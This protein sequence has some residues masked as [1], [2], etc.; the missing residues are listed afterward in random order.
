MHR[1]RRPSNASSISST[2]SNNPITKTM[3]SARNRLAS[4]GQSKVSSTNSSRASTPPSDFADASGRKSSIGSERSCSQ[5]PAKDVS[6]LWRCMLELQNEYGCYHSTRMDLA[7]DAGDAALDYMPSRFIID[8]LNDSI[9][10]LPE[11][12]WEKLDQYLR[13]PDTAKEMK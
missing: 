10:D 5:I 7:V 2:H 8:T 13:Q 9:F 6:E 3:R 12:A 1:S 4:R 11:E